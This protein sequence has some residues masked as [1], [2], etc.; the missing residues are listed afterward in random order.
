VRYRIVLKAEGDKTKLSVQ[1]AKGTADV[2]DNAKRIVALL[3]NEL[4]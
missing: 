1:D 2:G 4:R 3:G